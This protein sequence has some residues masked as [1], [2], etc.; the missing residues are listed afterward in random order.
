MTTFNE[1]LKKARKIMRDHIKTA[2]S[3]GNIREAETSRRVD[4]VLCLLCGY[5][6]Y[7]HEPRKARECGVSDSL[8]SFARRKCSFEVK[9]IA[10]GCRKH[11]QNYAPGGWFPL[12]GMARPALCY[13]G[14]YV[15]AHR[16][17]APFSIFR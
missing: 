10:A 17:C 14:F 4:N 2:E 1:K 3:A 11:R 6:P 5:D 8:S 16:S 12:P 7:E 9:S 13:G 15:V